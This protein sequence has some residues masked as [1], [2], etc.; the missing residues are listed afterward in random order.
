VVQVSENYD[1]FPDESLEYFEYDA[2][3]QGL[4]SIRIGSLSPIQLA[5]ALAPPTSL[6]L[7][8]L[9][10]LAE[11]AAALSL[12]EDTPALPELV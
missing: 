2:N 11:A 10:Q 5:K 12:V 9:A 8:P 4:P 3:R 1:N 7:S 6:L